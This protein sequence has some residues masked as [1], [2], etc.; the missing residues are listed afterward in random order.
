MPVLIEESVRYQLMH[1]VIL[2]Q[3]SGLESV[4]E[5]RILVFQESVQNLL[6]LWS[7]CFGNPFRTY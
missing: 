4:D 5:P 2:F 3:E 6:N 7:L 1:L